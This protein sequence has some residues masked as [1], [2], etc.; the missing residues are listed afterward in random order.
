M[1]GWVA[2]AQVAACAV[3][4]FP[5]VGQAQDV[6]IKVHHFLPA[7]GVI[8]QK[9]IGPWC[10]RLAKESAGKVKCTIAPDM[11][12]GGQP[13]DLLDQARRGV[14]D[15]AYTAIGFTPGRFPRLEAFE[16]PFAATGA[17]ATSRALWEFA[18]GPGADDTKDVQLLAV[19]AQGPGVLH[20]NRKPVA[21]AADLKGMRLRAPNRLVR[22]TLAAL[23]AQSVG[24]PASQ[25]SDAIAQGM[26]DGTLLPY[27]SLG[28][29][30]GVAAT[31]FHSETGP[32][33]RAIYTSVYVLVMSRKTFD[34]LPASTRKIIEDASGAPLSVA[35][36]KAMA[37][38][39]AAVRRSAPKGSVNVISPAE[40][41]A[42]RKLAQPAVEAWI[43]EMTRGGLDGKALVEVSQKLVAKHTK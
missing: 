30:G 2:A 12:L 31:K 6:Q 14:V 25:A 27:G 4:A 36:G 37:E 16:L 11:S 8:P 39:D 19:H 10:D 3:V 15:V 32:R 17:E 29:A 35:A 21:T 13:P 7:S 28:E 41:A 22:D 33:D 1:R 18:R 26:L 20:N 38:A 43:K 9:V 42:M 23:G 40:V 34:K 5:C 24:M